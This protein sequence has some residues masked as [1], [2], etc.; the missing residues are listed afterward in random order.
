MFALNRYRVR[1]DTSGSSSASRRVSAFS[2]AA[3]SPSTIRAAM[4][5]ILR[6]IGSSAAPESRPFPSTTASKVAFTTC[7]ASV[8][9]LL[10]NWVDAAI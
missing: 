8:N 5:S 4:T 6:P 1:I 9:W 2:A 7:T 10:R 3:A